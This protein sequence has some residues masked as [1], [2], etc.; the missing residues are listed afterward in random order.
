MLVRQS[1][2]GVRE[3]PLPSTHMKS[4][5]DGDVSSGRDM[6]T[7]GH[8]DMGMDMDISTFRD[9]NLTRMHE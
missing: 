9:H 1:L 5:E 3:G 2:L 8:G 7:H 6:E 4:L